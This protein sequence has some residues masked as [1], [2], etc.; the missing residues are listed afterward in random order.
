[1]AT[2]FNNTGQLITVATAARRDNLFG[3]LPTC[4]LPSP[5]IPFPPY[6]VLNAR[7]YFGDGQWRRSTATP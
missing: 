6:V 4:R 3:T 2:F 1:M 7:I 5:P